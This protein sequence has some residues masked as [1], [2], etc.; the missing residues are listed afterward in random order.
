[1]PIK[2]M[3]LEADSTRE[4]GMIKPMTIITGKTKNDKSVVKTYIQCLVAQR[5]RR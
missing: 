3:G 5:L 1:M 4:M 2:A